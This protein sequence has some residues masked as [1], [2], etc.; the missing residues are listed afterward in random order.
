MCSRTAWSGPLRRWPSC[1]PP[2]PWRQPAKSHV[3]PL[4]YP[5]P[6]SR[7]CDRPVMLEAMLKQNANGCSV[8]IG[9]FGGNMRKQSPLQELR[10]LP[11]HGSQCGD[12]PDQPACRKS[13][14]QIGRQARRIDSAAAYVRPVRRHARPG[15]PRVAVTSDK[16]IIVCANCQRRKNCRQRQLR[17][18]SRTSEDRFTGGVDPP[19]K[20]PTAE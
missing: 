15:K 17:V 18:E 1:L 19:A 3:C 13:G 16:A 10:T 11:L 4:S 14:V 6:E 2:R 8:Y 7:F 12:E 20:C 9:E 5:F